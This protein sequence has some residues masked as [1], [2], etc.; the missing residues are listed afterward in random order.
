MRGSRKRDRRPPLV[1][2][3]LRCPPDRKSGRWRAIQRCTGPP[4]PLR[5][6]TTWCCFG[7][8]SGALTVCRPCSIASAGRFVGV[9]AVLYCRPENLNRRRQAC[10][11]SETQISGGTPGG[12]NRRRRGVDTAGRCHRASK[13]PIW[14]RWTCPRQQGRRRRDRRQRAA[15]HRARSSRCR[16]S[17]DCGTAPAASGSSTTPPCPATA[18]PSRSAPTSPTACSPSARRTAGPPHRT[19]RP[20]HGEGRPDGQW[21]CSAPRPPTGCL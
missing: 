3:K 12:W 6:R 16:R 19:I 13:T 4:F 11:A 1:R 8:P 21:S 5:F 10:L 17:A 2:G 14:S 7:V 20:R 18:T 9:F 15:H